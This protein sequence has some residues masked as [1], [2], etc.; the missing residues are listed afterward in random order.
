MKIE[1]SDISK[2][3]EKVPIWDDFEKILKKEE[4][5]WVKLTSIDRL[6]H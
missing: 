4:G 5:N 2:I 6:I 3:G 1:P